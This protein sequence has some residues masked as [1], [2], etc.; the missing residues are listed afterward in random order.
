MKKGIIYLLALFSISAYANSNSIRVG[1]S[2][3][4][5]PYTFY[6]SD[7]LQGFE[8]DIWNA[9]GKKLNKKIVFTTAKFSG[10]FGLLESGKIDTISNQIT[11]TKKRLDKYDFT[12]PYVYDGASIIVH[13]NTNN[14]KSLD[15]LKG[16]KVG[17]GL[18]TNYAQIVKG[19]DKKNQIKVITYDGNGYLMDVGFKRLSAYIEDRN[20]AI[21]SIKKARF[22]L[23]VVGKPIEIISNAF[24]FLKN[25]KN[26]ALIKDIDSAITQLRK[27]GTFK[28]ISIK[29]FGKNITEK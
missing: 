24:P 9:I 15:D 16:K 26:K 19:H 6:K 8:I 21:Q 12:I 27:N 2:G 29:W 4:Y 28:T 25:E 18:G 7:K 13:K 10:L 3:G 1:T 17:V 23:K 14:I 11:I 22:P 20:S 5:F